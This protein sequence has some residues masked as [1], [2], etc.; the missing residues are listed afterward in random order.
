MK[1]ISKLNEGHMTSKSSLYQRDN[2]FVWYTIYLVIVTM[3][4]RVNMLHV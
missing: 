2:A 1:I 4:L 3:A